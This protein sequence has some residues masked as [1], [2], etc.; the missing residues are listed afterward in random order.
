MRMKIKIIIWL[1]TRL[2]VEK[3][4]RVM[5]FEPEEHQTIFPTV[6]YGGV[7]NGWTQSS[8]RYHCSGVVIG[9][10]VNSMRYYIT[11]ILVLVENYFGIKSY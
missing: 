2:T 10:P 8:C 3:L 5:R 6:D 1:S 7:L 9:L 4:G 11:H